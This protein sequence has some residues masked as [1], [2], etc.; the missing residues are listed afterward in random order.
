MGAAL[1][2]FYEHGELKAEGN[3]IT[4]GIGQGR[5]TANLEG[6]PSTPGSKSP[7]GGPA[8]HLRPCP[9]GGARARRL[10]RHQ[11]R[12]CRPRRQGA[13]PGPHDR[14]R[15]L[16]LRH[17]LPVQA[18]QPGLPAREGPALPPMAGVREPMAD[19]ASDPLVSTSWLA[20]HL[21]S[22]D[23]RVVDTTWYLPNA[24]RDPRADY[25]AAHIPGA[26]FSTSTTSRTR[27]TLIRT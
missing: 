18:L 27:P 3:S 8:L 2:N 6:R 4:E 14:D 12:R 24:G 10:L 1:Y 19:N 23:I 7:R 5:I 20:Q 25:A 21:D 13:G 15:A 11:H 22:P 16:R 17:P 26:V 9:R